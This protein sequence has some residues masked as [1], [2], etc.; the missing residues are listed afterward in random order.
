MANTYPAG[1][2]VRVATYTGAIGS[3]TGG[4]RDANGNLA[5]PTTITLKYSSGGTTTT[6]V[7]PSAPIIKDGVGLYHADLDTTVNSSTKSWEWTYEWLG[8]GTIQ[9]GA[10]STFDVSSG[11]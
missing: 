4:F 3:P 11:L 1:S 8:T 6:V 10:Q 9:A 7:Y 2:L 5:D